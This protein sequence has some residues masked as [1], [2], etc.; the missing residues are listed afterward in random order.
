MRFIFFFIII[1]KMVLHILHID[2]ILHKL[3]TPNIK[4]DF[5]PGTVAYT[6]NPIYSGGRDQED[7][8]SKP[9]WGV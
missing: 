3:F 9:A 8:S 2:F 1:I 6:Y 7:R 4:T 5:L